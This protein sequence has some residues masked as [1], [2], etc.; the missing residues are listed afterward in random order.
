MW[1]SNPRLLG[2]KTIYIS[3]ALLPHLCC[4]RNIC[5]LVLKYWNF[6]RWVTF[7]TWG[8]HNSKSLTDQSEILA[9][10][11]HYIWL[12]SVR[13]LWQVVCLVFIWRIENHHEKQTFIFLYNISRLTKYTTILMKIFVVK[14]SYYTI[15]WGMSGVWTPDLWVTRP[16]T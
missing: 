8:A 3:C 13:F 4:I 16:S 1:G 15:S 12:Y 7:S 2:Y 5:R 10:H 11:W 14:I 9:I 6:S